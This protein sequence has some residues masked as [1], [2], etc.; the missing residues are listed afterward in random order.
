MRLQRMCPIATGFSDAD[1]LSGQSQGTDTKL[2]YF[3]GYPSDKSP[4]ITVNLPWKWL[5]ILEKAY[6]GPSLNL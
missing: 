5:A 3:I 4:V 2:Y 1:W 6:K